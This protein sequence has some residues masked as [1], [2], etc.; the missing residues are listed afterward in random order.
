MTSV[1][2]DLIIGNVVQITTAL[3]EVFSGE[4]FAFEEK[5]GVVILRKYASFSFVVAFAHA[6]AY[7]LAR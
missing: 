1:A 3:G 4:I 7:V 2:A 5:T 6:S